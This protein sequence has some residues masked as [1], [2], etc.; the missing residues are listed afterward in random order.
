M[1]RAITGFLDREESRFGP[2]PPESPTFSFNK[3]K[4]HADWH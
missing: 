1:A 2:I 4:A 3:R